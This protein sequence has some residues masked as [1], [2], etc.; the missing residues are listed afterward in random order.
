LFHLVLII[1]GVL[2]LGVAATSV[3]GEVD[4]HAE[5]PVR[6]RSQQRQEP[7]GRGVPAE[8]R[9]QAVSKAAGTHGEKLSE[10][11]RIRDEIRLKVQS[12]LGSLG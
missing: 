4:P 10:V 12:F 2:P 11:R 9:G 3:E 5:S 8:I 7:D 6:V 1:L